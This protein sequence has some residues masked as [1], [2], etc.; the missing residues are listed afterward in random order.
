MDVRRTGRARIESR[1]ESPT[2]RK[3]GGQEDGEEGG[4][5]VGARGRYAASCLSRLWGSKPHFLSTV[6]LRTLLHTEMH[7]YVTTYIDASLGHREH[8]ALVKK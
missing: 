6:E 2:V 1:I 8:W 3:E 5:E 4:L 7:L